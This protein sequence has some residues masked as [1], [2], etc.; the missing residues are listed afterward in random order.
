[1]DKATKTPT[2]KCI[3]L[4]HPNLFF[5]RELST[6]AFNRRVLSLAQ[7]E[8]IPLL[9]RL[10]FLCIFSA[11]LDEFF[12]VRVAGIKQQVD[13]NILGTDCYALPPDIALEKIHEQR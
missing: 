10:K 13:N 2:T 9:E 1:M 7:D 5:D 6:L 11:N 4:K 8:S 12:E 3:D